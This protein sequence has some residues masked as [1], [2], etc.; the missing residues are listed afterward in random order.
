[1]PGGMCVWQMSR[2]ELCEHVDSSLHGPLA[3]EK[4]RNFIC[5]T[6]RCNPTHTYYPF[7][8]HTH[9]H[10]H[11]VVRGGLECRFWC[12]AW[13]RGDRRQSCRNGADAAE[14]LADPERKI[15]ALI[16]QYECFNYNV[17]KWRNVTN[18]DK[19]TFFLLV[20]FMFLA[21]QQ[22]ELP[23]SHPAK[24]VRMS[25]AVGLRHIVNLYRHKPRTY[26]DSL[27]LWQQPTSW[28]ARQR[29]SW[30]KMN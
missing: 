4:I 20:L 30:R 8:T 25:S 29:L 3:S 6:L 19:F 22:T 7:N 18:C 27:L 16:E 10:T 15:R 12:E 9:T 21:V 28:G 23:A 26:H 17:K 14:L 11:Q 13:R 24:E 2:A 5:A 1:M